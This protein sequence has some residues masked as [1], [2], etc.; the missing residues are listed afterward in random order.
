MQEDLQTLA[1]GCLCA[2]PDR[3]PS[4]LRH[5]LETIVKLCPA[6]CKVMKDKRLVMFHKGIALSLHFYL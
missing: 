2:N 5:A 6:Y 4:E 3:P 1:K